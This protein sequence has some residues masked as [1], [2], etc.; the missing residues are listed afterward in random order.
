M[1]LQLNMIWMDTYPQN[2]ICSQMAL[3][4]ILLILDQTPWIEG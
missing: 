4:D 2:I 3:H 1:G